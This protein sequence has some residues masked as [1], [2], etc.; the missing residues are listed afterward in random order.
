M[1]SSHGLIT[2]VSGLSPRTRKQPDNK[3]EGREHQDEYDP[4]NLGAC[5]NRALE[6]IDYSPHVKYKDKQSK[7]TADS[8][9]INPPLEFKNIASSV[10]SQQGESDEAGKRESSK[11]RKCERDSRFLSFC[12]LS[13]ACLLF[14]HKHR[15]MM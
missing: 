7:K 11:G 8:E 5:G 15:C 13:A 9:H 12:P 6:N 1:L 4:E 14:R 3:T 2:S 10:K